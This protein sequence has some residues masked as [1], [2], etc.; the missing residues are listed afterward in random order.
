MGQGEY[1]RPPREAFIPDKEYLQEYDTCEGIILGTTVRQPLLTIRVQLDGEAEPR[2]IPQ[3]V[4]AVSYKEL[5]KLAPGKKIM[6]HKWVTKDGESGEAVKLLPEYAYEDGNTDATT[7]LTDAEI[8]KMIDGAIE[9]AE[10]M[11]TKKEE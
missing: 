3:Y 1:K 7:V 6:Y 4:W 10:K 11:G 2:F 5:K 9:E 8:E